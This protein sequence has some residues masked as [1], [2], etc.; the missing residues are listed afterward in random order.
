MVLLLIC[1]GTPQV[2]VLGDVWFIFFKVL[3]KQ[4]AFVQV[5]FQD[6]F[7]AQVSNRVCLQSSFTGIIQSLG[8]IGFMELDDPHSSFISYFRI[9]YRGDYFL[10]TAQH[11]LAM[12]GRFLFKKFRTPIAIVFMGTA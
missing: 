5:V 3:V 12:Y 9:V 2:I 8:A 7:N 4:G 11:V 1:R 10:N 6:I